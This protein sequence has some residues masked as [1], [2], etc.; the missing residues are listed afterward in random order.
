[1]QPLDRIEIRLHDLGDL[2]GAWDPETRIIWLHH[3]LTHPERRSTIA[4]ELVHALRG[5]EACIDPVLGARQENSVDRVAVRLLITL[6][7]FAEALAW[8]ADDV[9][10]AH[11]LCIDIRMVQAMRE[12]LT[13]DE[14]AY[15]EDRL[16]LVEKSA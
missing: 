13:A 9:A 7:Q 8:C 5:D 15:V 1:V 4:H 10:V 14:I 16:A 6:D 2:A 3:D 11:E 12:S